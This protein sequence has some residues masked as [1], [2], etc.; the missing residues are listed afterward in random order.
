[1]T[2]IYGPE[3]LVKDVQERNLCI[4]CGACVNLCPYFRSYRGKTAMLFPC[5]M[6]RGR[7]YAHCPKAEVDFD[8][9]SLHIQGKPYDG[10]PLGYYR[11]AVAGK[12]GEKMPP[13]VN[14][15]FYSFG[16]QLCNLT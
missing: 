10:S 7:C 2:K 4:G 14:L 12:A 5:D 6:P 16:K 1:M 3:A 8:E 15:S 13:A 11:R 9:L